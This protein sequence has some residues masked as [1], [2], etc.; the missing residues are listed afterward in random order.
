MCLAGAEIQNVLYMF[1]VLF[2]C[3][4]FVIKKKKVTIEQTKCKLKQQKLGA[5]E[6]AIFRLRLQ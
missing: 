6:T 1:F 5:R 3:D 4:V 2:F